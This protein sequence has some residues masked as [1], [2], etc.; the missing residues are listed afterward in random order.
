MKGIQDALSGKTPLMTSEE[1]RATLVN[2]QQKVAAQREQNV[3]KE[4]QK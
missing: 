4:A 1:Q 2:L 3:D